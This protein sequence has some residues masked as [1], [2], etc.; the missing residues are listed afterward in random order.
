M[1]EKQTT[2]PV[3]RRIRDRLKTYGS[4]GET[5][6]DILARMMDEVEREQFLARLR[7]EIDDPETEW[8]DLEDSGWDE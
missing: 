3:S 4:M 7:K 5:Y 6:N 1:A 2:I 8:V